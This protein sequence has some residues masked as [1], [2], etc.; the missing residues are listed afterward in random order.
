[1]DMDGDGRSDQ[2]KVK[3][4]ISMNGGVVDAEMLPEDGSIAGKMTTETN[5]L[6]QGQKPTDKTN[7]KLTKGYTTMIDD[8]QRLGIQMIT[9]DKLLDQMGV[10][11]EKRVTDLSRG[12]AGGTGAKQEKQPFRKRTAGSAY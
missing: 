10:T 1:M 7:E 2:A 3:S 6:V 11:A 4:I 12:G 5:Y 8:A 9:L